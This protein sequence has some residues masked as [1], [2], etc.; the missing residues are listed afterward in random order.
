[1]EVKKDEFVNEVILAG[2]EIGA[3][4]RALLAMEDVRI[5]IETLCIR[6]TDLELDKKEFMECLK[7]VLKANFALDQEKYRFLPFNFEKLKN[8]YI[9]NSAA[10]NNK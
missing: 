7:Y 5:F 6:Y 8:I 4:M 1:L 9:F 10:E 3:P 2:E